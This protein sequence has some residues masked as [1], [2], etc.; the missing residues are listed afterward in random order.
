MEF[1]GALAILVVCVIVPLIN[2]SIIPI[3]YGMA[4]NILNSRVHKLALSERYSDAL[5]T[6]N[7]GVGWREALSKLNG[8]SVKSSAVTLCI[9]S[10]NAKD[11]ILSVTRAG[12]IPPDWLPNGVMAPCDYF[13]TLKVETEIDPLITAPIW[14]RKIGGINGPLFFTIEQTAHWENLGRDPSTG[15]FFVD[16]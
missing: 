1:A 15:N 3:R 16:E 9:S 6:G 10:S 7:G 14:G 11:R 4:Q 2:L 8:I 5:S 13:L 12:E